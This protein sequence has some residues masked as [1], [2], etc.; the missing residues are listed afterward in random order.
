MF[1]KKK[2]IKT[3]V[4]TFDF[5]ASKES[6]SKPVEEASESVDGQGPAAQAA[7]EAKVEKPSDAVAAPDEA[8]A[9][10][11]PFLAVQGEAPETSGP[12]KV[13]GVFSRQKV[14]KIGT[15]TTSRRV[16]QQSYFFAEELPDGQISL[17]PLSPLH[18]PSGPTEILSKEELLETMLPEPEMYQKEVLPKLR[19][20]QKNI[21]RGDRYRK[22]GKTFSAE[23]EYGKALKIDVDN[24]RANFS[25][26]LCYLE[27][28]DKVK[29]NEVF[30]RL[31]KL[32]AAFEQGHKHLFNEF[33]INLR[34]SNMLDQAVDYYTRALELTEDD[35]NLHYN[36]AR[37]YFE[38]GNSK[39]SAEHLKECLRLNP[40]HE[41][42]RKFVEYLKKRKRPQGGPED[43]AAA[44]D[45]K[46]AKDGS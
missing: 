38:Q 20:I 44:S 6:E 4:A 8:E 40:S 23:M 2:K 22:Q 3:E 34:K 46:A 37:A 39:Q 15:G 26:G 10:D 14:S 17:Q 16:L 19:D 35:E 45:G 31:V 1:N 9:E 18:I 13:L 36:A 32:D 30:E 42:A 12:G 28:D 25:I 29:A 24:I 21:A 41:P 11:K 43:A 7:E 33:G 5:A 27:R